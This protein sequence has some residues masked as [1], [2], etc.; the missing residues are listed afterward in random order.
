[1]QT[2]GGGETR[3]GLK[4]RKLVQTG[5]TQPY[6]LAATACA[7]L[8]PVLRRRPQSYPVP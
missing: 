3:R 7:D 5:Q 4:A 1:M 2:R 6:R 8:T